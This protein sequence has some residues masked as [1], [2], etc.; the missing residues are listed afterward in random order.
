MENE[1][2]QNKNKKK[3][4]GKKMLERRLFCD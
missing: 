1:T 4:L 3:E 2:K